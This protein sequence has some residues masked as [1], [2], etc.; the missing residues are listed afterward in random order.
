MFFRLFFFTVI[1]TL[2]ASSVQAIAN[3]NNKLAELL[4]DKNTFVTDFEQISI[5]S[6]GENSQVQK[7]TMS[8]SRP[9]RFRWQVDSPIPQLVVSDGKEVFV[10]DE[11]LEQVTINTLEAE[12]L[13]TPALLLSGNV[14]AIDGNF[15]VTGQYYGETSEFILLPTASDNIF[16]KLVLRFVKNDLS[17]ME[18]SDSF[19]QKSIIIFSNSRVN[20][21]IAAKEFRFTIP[22]NVDVFRQE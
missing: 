21:D 11:L 10:Y 9:N 3:D 14:D 7:G 15:E 6:D 19:G 13:D 22:E 18:I 17:E 8:V 4:S 1:F 16:E 20:E 2:L 5:T 12:K